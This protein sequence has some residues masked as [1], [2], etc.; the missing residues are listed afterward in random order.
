PVLAVALI[1][2]SFAKANDIVSGQGAVTWQK[3]GD[4]SR[5]RTIADAF[6]YFSRL[7]A[8]VHPIILLGALLLLL[9][10]SRE[11]ERERSAR[12][13]L[14]VVVLSLAGFL[15]VYLVTPQDLVWHLSTSMLRVLLQVW[16]ALA[17]AWM[18]LLR[19]PEDLL[20]GARAE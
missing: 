10:F 16:P 2:K 17:L 19:S 20:R 15:G 5:Y 14:I 12:A 13:A 9:G 11:R 4:W 8:S 3:L 1:Q 6:S 18:L 7:E